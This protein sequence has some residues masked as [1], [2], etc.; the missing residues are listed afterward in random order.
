MSLQ[1]SSSRIGEH[2]LNTWRCLCLGPCHGRDQTFVVDASNRQIVQLKQQQLALS[3]SDRTSRQW[4]LHLKPAVSDVAKAAR[5]VSA[6][7]QKKH[8]ELRQLWGVPAS[9]TSWAASQDLPGVTARVL[10]CIDICRDVLMLRHDGMFPSSVVLDVS[11]DISRRAW[12]IGAVPTITR[13]SDY[14]LFDERRFCL[15]CEHMRLLGF[16]LSRLDMTGLTDPQA[17]DLAGDSMSLPCCTS[18]VLSVAHC[19]QPHT[20]AEIE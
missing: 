7:W 14:F 15:G 19:L 10:D 18:V 6:T 5:P 16:D 17:R 3:L 2:R 12:C 4:K 13:S 8:Q 1:A 11:Q 20:R 9:P